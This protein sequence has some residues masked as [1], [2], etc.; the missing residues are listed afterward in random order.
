MTSGEINEASAPDMESI[1]D[2][3]RASTYPGRGIILGLSEDGKASVLLYFTMGR[4]VNSRNRIFERTH[5]GIRT[6]AFDPAKLTDPDLVIYNAVR[7]CKGQTIVTNGDQTDTIYEHLIKDCD[8]RSALRTREFEPD[9]PLYTPRI[10]GLVG[11]D[12]SYCLSILKTLNGDSARC[13][14]YFFEYPA[15]FPG[16]GHFISTYVTDG[17]PPPSFKGEPIPV[18]ITVA[19]GLEAFAQTVWDALNDENKVSL[20]A[21][22]TAIAT[23]EIYDMIINKNG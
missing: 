1:G 18:K 7:A 2:L 14:R 3:L 8:F 16:E 4:S 11:P 19:T 9:A 20:Y 21:R 15:A 12:G 23:G 17:N 5:D 13:C 6:A 22:E 10:S